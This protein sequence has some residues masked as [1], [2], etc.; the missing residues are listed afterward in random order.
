MREAAHEALT[1]LRQGVDERMAY[2]QYRHSLSQAEEGA[3]A[4][5]LP[6]GGHDRMGCSTDQVKLTHP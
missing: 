3:K 4:V 2:S 5:I 1:V 6:A